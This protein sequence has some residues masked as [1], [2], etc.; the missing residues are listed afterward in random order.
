MDPFIAR[1][2]LASSRSAY[3]RGDLAREVHEAARSLPTAYFAR[4]SS[5]VAV[6]S[7]PPLN[8]GSSVTSSTTKRRFA[9]GL[10]SERA[11][12]FGPG[13]HTS[14]PIELGVRLAR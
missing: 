3:K 10:R 8:N 13:D 9:F 5:S 11:K 1:R 2:Q 4:T 14:D 6:H 12:L 7:R